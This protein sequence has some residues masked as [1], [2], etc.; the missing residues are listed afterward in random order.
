[1]TQQNAAATTKKSLLK[2]RK[3]KLWLSPEE[4]ASISNINGAT[5]KSESDESLDTY[6]TLFQS[7][8]SPSEPLSLSSF[9][10][11]TLPVGQ[12]FVLTV[13]LLA[14][15]RIA[16]AEQTSNSIHSFSFQSDR[17]WIASALIWSTLIIS[18]V[19]TRFATSQ[20][21]QLH[22]RA[23]DFALMAVLLRFL[24]AVLKTL[25]ASYSS[26][27]VYALSI[28]ALFLHLLACNYAYANGWSDHKPGNNTNDDENNSETPKMPKRPIFKGGTLSLTSVFFATA[29]L[30]SRLQ[31]NVTVYVFVCFSV[32]LFALYPAARHLVAVQ[33]SAFT[34]VIITVILTGALMVL[35][36]SEKEMVGVAVTLFIIL[37]L[38]PLWKHYLQRYKVAL[39]GPWDIAHV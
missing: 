28:A 35:L 27:T 32:I 31:N 7:F 1:M 16:M 36:E 12:E 11:N 34:P 25:T 18:V 22:H 15:H 21:Y 13:I 30:A 26:D 3:R 33:G 39:R 8:S 19:Q 37:L 24:S 38:V 4:F 29:L 20:Q 9:L 14:G 17:L 23:T 2:N 5:A 10:W 6:E